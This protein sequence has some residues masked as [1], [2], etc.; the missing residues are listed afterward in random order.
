MLLVIILSV[1]QYNSESHSTDIV[2]A[3]RDTPAFIFNM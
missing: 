3:I 1:I 2:L